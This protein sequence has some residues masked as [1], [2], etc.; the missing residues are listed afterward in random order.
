MVEAVEVVVEVAG[1][2]K[3]M[4]RPRSRVMVV[5]EV[6]LVEVVALAESDYA[7]VLG[8]QHP[9]LSSMGLPPKPTAAPYR[10]AEEH[11]QLEEVEE[12]WKWEEGEEART[13]LAKAIGL[14]MT[15]RLHRMSQTLMK[16]LAMMFSGM[17][18]QTGIAQKLPLG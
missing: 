11:W 1:V 18:A 8:L 9:P 5:L 17:L 15:G 16:Y 2:V 6:V 12:Q 13:K 10:A 14:L 4:V 7:P 3:E